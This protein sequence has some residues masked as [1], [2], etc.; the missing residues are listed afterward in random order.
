MLVIRSFPRDVAH[1]DIKLSNIILSEN[2]DDT[3][4][5]KIADF[6]LASKSSRRRCLEEPY[7]CQ[8]PE[9]MVHCWKKY[10]TEQNYPEDQLNAVRF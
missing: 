6:G 10:Y 7:I 5:V 1:R 4:T 8:A 2:G 3:W 9:E